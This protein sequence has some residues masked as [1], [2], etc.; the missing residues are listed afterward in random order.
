M[1]IDVF[2]QTSGLL[3]GVVTHV[4]P[5][6][7]DFLITDAGR[8]VAVEMTRYHQAP[9]P[10]GSPLAKRVAGENRIVTRALQIFEATNP[11]VHLL[12]DFYFGYESLSRRN[13]LELPPL[14]A[15]AVTALI[16]PL[17]MTAGATTTE[18]DYR[19]PKL[20]LLRTVLLGVHVLR[21]RSLHRNIWDSGS[22]GLYSV[23]ISELERVMRT[24]E[25]DLPRYKK[26]ADECWLIIYGLPQGSA[27]FDPGC[28]RPICGSQPLTELASLTSSLGISFWSRDFRA[29]LCTSS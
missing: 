9:G 22:G 26:S 6:P 4:R 5:D 21:S 18:A 13:V 17:S 8:R 10:K 12:V 23:D 20:A 19:D 3:P 2:H 15:D 14:L 1:A 7:P 11:N 24:K 25:A 28:S 29:G 16:P 27:L